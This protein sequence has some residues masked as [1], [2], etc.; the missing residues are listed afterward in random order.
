MLSGD[1][2]QE[3]VQK[4]DVLNAFYCP[5]HWEDQVRTF[6][7]DL[8]TQLVETK[9]ERLRGNLFQL[10]AVREY[11]GHHN[12]RLEIGPLTSPV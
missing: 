8:T 10:D 12:V 1:G 11:V 5:I 2:P 7:E 4:S 9:S 3:A 6:Y